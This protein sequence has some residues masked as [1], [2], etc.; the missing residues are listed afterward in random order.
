MMFK[1]LILRFRDLVTPVGQTIELHKKIIEEH[2]SH[3]V[4]WGWWAKADEQC[5]RE[6]TTLKS[7]VSDDNPLKIYL[8]DSFQKKLYAALLNELTISF[9]KHNCPDNTAS[10]E[11]YSHQQYNVWFRFSSITEVEDSLNEIKGWAYSGAVSDF[12]ANEDM[13]SIF[14]DKQIFSLDEL[15]C[16]DR[17]IWFVDEFC[18][19]RHNTHEV[20]LSN[21]NVSVPGVFP[22]RPIELSTGK[23]LWF[24]DL[25]FDENKKYHQFDQRDQK[26]LNTIIKDWRN[27]V[28]G[29][30]I[31]GDITWRATEAE[32]KTA[33]LFLENLCSSKKI[34]IDGIGMCPGNHDV[35][36]CEDY[37][38]NVK[39]A[40]SKYHDLQHGIGA[41][42]EDEWNLLVAVDVLPEYKKNYEVFFKSIVST[43][44]NEYLSMGKRF[45][46]KNQKV[47]DVCFLNSNSLQ[48]HKLAFQGQGYVGIGQRDHAENEMGWKR[49]KKISGGYRV[50]VL[51]H[52]LYPVN[53]TNTPYISAPSGL[54]YDTEAILK[55]CF[56]NG[57][58][59]ILHGHTHERCVNKIIRKENDVEKSIWIVSLGSTGVVQGHLVGNNEFAELDFEGDKIKVL[60]Y[61]IVNNVIVENNQIE[62]D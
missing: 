12:F 31:S 27:E 44:A 35:S 24:S 45:L 42:S 26:E 55:W 43:N 54:V 49:N 21:A 5:P 37:K 60:F 32:F 14:T 6:F 4:W 20:V 15:R 58:D 50:V 10:P 52:N 57:V 22:K 25:H 33:Q 46:I 59:L 41:L 48:Q 16:Q 2:A 38:D 39:Q 47:V 30:I 9:E 29:L 17:T 19:E 53:Y 61:N 36:F 51:H 3:S 13:F 62:L 1:T 7:E 18:A 28:E 23:I 11:Y 40:L 8:F 56:E 34:N